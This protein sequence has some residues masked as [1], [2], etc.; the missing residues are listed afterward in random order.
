M[1]AYNKTFLGID[2]GERRI[3][4]AKSDPTGMIASALK[5]LEVKSNANALAQ[6]EIELNEIEPDGIVVGYPLSESGE[7]SKMCLAID[8]FI[9]RL[10][11]IY[12]GP[13][14]KID[15]RYSS[16]EAES[17]IHAHG[18]K[19]GQDKKRVDRLAAVIILQRFLDGLERSI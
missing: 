18:K 4:L 17:I 13:V 7:I 5:T 12:T 14:H 10:R 8:R 6:L 15:E 9:E 19:I 3:G 1:T 16:L 11:T 2:F